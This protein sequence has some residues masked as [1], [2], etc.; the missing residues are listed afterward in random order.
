MFKN[1]CLN[2]SVCYAC[3]LFLERETNNNRPSS[4]HPKILDND[5]PLFSFA[6][7]NVPRAHRFRRRGFQGKSSN[8]SVGNISSETYSHLLK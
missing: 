3:N 8:A 7:E 5:V 6:D 4:L 1:G 2:H